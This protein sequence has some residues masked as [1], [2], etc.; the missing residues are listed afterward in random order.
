MDIKD[1]EKGEN[2][3]AWFEGNHFVIELAKEDT[4]V[5]IR[6][7][8]ILPAVETYLYRGN[9]TFTELSKLAEKEGLKGVGW[10]DTIVWQRQKHS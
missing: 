8:S 5:V 2:F 3:I 1:V 9:K 6:L 10:N 4:A 7:A